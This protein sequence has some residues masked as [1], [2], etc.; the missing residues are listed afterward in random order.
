MQ[1]WGYKMSSQNPGGTSPQRATAEVL[2]SAL[3]QLPTQFGSQDTSRII[4]EHTVKNVVGAAKYLEAI[5]YVCV[6]KKSV[7]ATPRSYWVSTSHKAHTKGAS[8][9]ASQA[10]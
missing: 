5:F 10:A 7:R 1:F 6:F 8:W 3:P 9:G 4:P 2:V